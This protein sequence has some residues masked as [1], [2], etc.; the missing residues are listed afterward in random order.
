MKSHL[1]AEQPA[2][3][4]QKGS[5]PDNDDSPMPM[6][7]TTA[8]KPDRSPQELL[9]V[10]ANDS[11][12]RQL[13][14]I[15]QNEN[16]SFPSV[17]NHL[18][19]RGSVVIKAMLSF[20]EKVITRLLCGEN[21][22][23]VIANPGGPLLATQK[24]PEPAKQHVTMPTRQQAPD[25]RNP[26]NDPFSD[27]FFDGFFSDRFFRSAASSFFAGPGS[28]HRT[29]VQAANRP[30]A[31]QHSHVTCDRCKEP[32]TMRGGYHCN[33]CRGGD[34]DVCTDCVQE[35]FGCL[36]PSHTLI[37]WIVRVSP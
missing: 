5:P 13:V 23:N 10:L 2:S 6:V 25:F 32:F 20:D 18:G 29:R 36:N 31:L 27:P 11:T 19:N 37:K 9:R 3:S 17:V 28:A 7:R 12:F 22:D 26:F 15:F 34:F 21:V 30:S 1:P 33:I 14:K 4:A 35:N 16:R 8:S 24:A